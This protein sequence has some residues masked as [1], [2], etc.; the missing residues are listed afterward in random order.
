MSRPLCNLSYD[1]CAY[2]RQRVVEQVSLHR[3]PLNLVYSPLRILC[4]LEN[5]QSTKTHSRW[6]THT[7]NRVKETSPGR[8]VSFHSRVADRQGQ[9]KSGWLAVALVGLVVAAMPEGDPRGCLCA[10]SLCFLIF[11]DLIPGDTGGYSL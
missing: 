11:L 10:D 6:R 7:R 1:V 5:E 9:W 3:N 8:A 2:P 4:S